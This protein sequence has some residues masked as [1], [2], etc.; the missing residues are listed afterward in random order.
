MIQTGSTCPGKMPMPRKLIDISVPLRNDTISDPPGNHP[1]IR[2]V[3]HQQ[4][5]PHM[6]QFFDGLTAQPCPSGRVGP[7]NRSRSP[8]TTA[9]IS[10]PPGISTPP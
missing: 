6:L 7:W 9:R 1:A 8:R 5:L 3:D 10:M 4:G 2:Y